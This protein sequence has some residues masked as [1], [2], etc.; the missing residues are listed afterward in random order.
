LWFPL[1]KVRGT[2]F[3]LGNI[4]GDA[5]DSLKISLVKGIGKDFATGQTYGD[6]IDVYAAFNNITVK[7][8]ADQLMATLGIRGDEP[9]KKRPKRAR[10]IAHKRLVERMDSRRG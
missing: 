4:Q 8:A 10:S 5:G 7:E 2:E 6:L 3:V 1:G 9:I